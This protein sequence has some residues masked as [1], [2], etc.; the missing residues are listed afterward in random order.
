MM[1]D[2]EWINMRDTILPKQG[3]TGISQ[4]PMDEWR[5]YQKIVEEVMF[6]NT[7]NLDSFWRSHSKE[8]PVLH[9]IA[10]QNIWTPVNSVEFSAALGMRSFIR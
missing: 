5:V 8:L 6:I 2:R 10:L 4:I 7:E 3:V 1:E 9:A